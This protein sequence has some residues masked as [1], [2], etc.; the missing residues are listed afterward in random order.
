MGAYN[1]GNTQ[2]F[3]EGKRN[4][5]PEPGGEPDC[6]CKSVQASPRFLRPLVR[7]LLP[8]RTITVSEKSLHPEVNRL[9]TS[10]LGLQDTASEYRTKVGIVL[11]ISFSNVERRRR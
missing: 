2:E 8:I 9:A 7:R 4:P 5:I 6:G 3:L 10:L 1:Y 11:R